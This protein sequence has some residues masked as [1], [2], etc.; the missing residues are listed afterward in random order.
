[1]FRVDLTQKQLVL[2]VPKLRFLFSC[3]EFRQLS[4]STGGLSCEVTLEIRGSNPVIGKDFLAYS[5]NVQSSLLSGD[6]S[7]G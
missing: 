1:V 7:P 2:G 6:T 4:R 3:Y 5:F